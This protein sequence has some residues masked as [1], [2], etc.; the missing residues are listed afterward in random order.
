MEVTHRSAKEPLLVRALRGESVER[1]PVW[2]M[3]Q[4]GRWDPEFRKLRGP[5]SFYEF[6]ENAEL[7]AAASLCPLRFGVDAIILLYDITTLAVSMGQR[8]DLVPLRSPVPTRPIRCRADVDR[9]LEEPDPSSY[10]HVLDI[11]DIVK[12]EVGSDTPILVFAGAPFTLAAYQTGIGK[13]IERLRAFLREESATWT[14]LLEKTSRA[15]VGFLKCLMGRGASAYQLFDSWAGGLTARE[16]ADYAHPYHETIIRETGG[17]VY[18]FCEGS[19]FC[20]TGCA[21]RGDSSESGDE[22]R[23]GPTKE[24][25]SP[26]RLSRKCRSYVACPR[27]GRRGAAGYGPMCGA[28]GRPPTCL[29]SGSRD[30]SEC[31]C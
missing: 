24:I 26:Y 7:A 1:T 28:G 30:G 6:S 5:H 3:R 18:P 27:D 31:A 21:E 2:A 22:P 29:E 20:R 14:A 17:G 12:R 4:A 13:D 8:F 9:L 10:Q 19:P 15:T 11:L 25:L 23:F 16:Y